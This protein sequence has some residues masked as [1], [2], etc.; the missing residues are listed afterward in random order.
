MFPKNS[1]LDFN[2]KSIETFLFGETFSISIEVESVLYFGILTRP[3]SH[4]MP[5]EVNRV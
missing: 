2:H 3:I 4:E 5:A 1:S